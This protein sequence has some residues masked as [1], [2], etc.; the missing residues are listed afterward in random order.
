MSDGMW[1]M[2]KWIYNTNMYIII[3]KGNA[4]EIKYMKISNYI[5][6]EKNKIKE[7]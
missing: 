3:M 5:K 1:I 2:S 7:T 6:K 4:L